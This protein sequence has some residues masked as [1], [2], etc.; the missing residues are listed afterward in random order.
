M[1]NFFS[2][3]WR[4]KEDTVSYTEAEKLILASNYTPMKPTD[5]FKSIL[6]EKV[7]N[8]F[9]NAGEGEFFQFFSRKFIFSSV[10]AI[11]IIVA[12]GFAF[13]FKGAFPLTP[14]VPVVRASEQ[15]VPVNF[16]IRVK[17]PY[18]NVS[19][20]NLQK[21]FSVT[22]QTEGTVSFENGILTFDHPKFL[23]YKTEYAFK[24]AKDASAEMDK[25][26]EIKF[27]TRQSYKSGFWFSPNT[28]LAHYSLNY[29]EP[30]PEVIIDTGDFI[31]TKANLYK[32]SPEKLLDFA[33]SVY[34]YE[35]D[36]EKEK[37]YAPLKKDLIE[38]K[39]VVSVSDRED[40]RG[41]KIFYKP[42]LKDAGIYFVEMDDFKFFITYSRYAVSSKKLNDKLVRWV[43]DTKTGEGVPFAKLTAYK[44]D[45]KT[46][47]LL[48]EETADDK[49]LHI[50]DVPSGPDAYKSYPV[51]EIVEAGD[52]KFVNI[53]NMRQRSIFDGGGSWCW[54]WACSA[55]YSGYVMTDRPLY[56]PGNDVQFKVMLRKKGEPEYDGSIKTAHVE[57]V[58][59][60]YGSPSNETVFK[61]D[62][63]VGKTGTFAGNAG[64]SRELKTGNYDILVS[65]GEEHIAL[66]AF[67]VEVFQ[68]PDFEVSVKADKEKY[69]SGQDVTVN[70]SAKYFF[71]TPVKDQK[72]TVS[73]AS[74]T[75]Y[76][77]DVGTK[78]VVLDN[79]GNA[80][81][82]FK[83]LK[84]PE[85]A[86]NYWYSDE[87]PFIVKATVKE[88]TG[89]SVSKN[90]TVLFY[91]SEYSVKLEEPKEIWRLR[92]REK[93]KFAF[94]VV[95]NLDNSEMNGV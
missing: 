93:N 52:E 72:A 17:F 24:V 8:R 29:Y 3:F 48:F 62:Y 70:V 14:E 26:F 60:Q 50:W 39:K 77:I 31:Q 79:N 4:K 33:V 76:G 91:E 43:V 69:I 83:D 6:K 11:L 40:N 41:Q 20:E 27:T 23:K 71:G 18:S 74:N 22:P 67:G 68:K 59:D 81:V 32:V 58:R 36:E 86:G 65:V 84:V 53:L 88:N 85:E 90:A 30:E 87:I 75:Y 42:K 34:S 44:Q 7:L 9:S 19:P 61:Q 55:K 35:N 66:A 21:Y 89:K 15:S 5:R 92:P 46:K 51:A 12:L 37:L 2:K 13:L 63:E 80:T 10:A 38:T 1:F 47:K 16:P 78:D 94:R 82:T 49:G 73:I 45:E 64:L 57:I 28:D 25:D 95:R 56:S 54:Q